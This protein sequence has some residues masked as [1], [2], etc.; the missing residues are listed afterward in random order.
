M[1][2]LD[3]KYTL[4]SMYDKRNKPGLRKLTSLQSTPSGTCQKYNGNE[5]ILKK[6]YKYHHIPNILDQSSMH[7]Q[8]QADFASEIVGVSHTSAMLSDAG[9]C[10]SPLLAAN[11]FRV[12]FTKKRV[13]TT[14]MM[15]LLGGYV[16]KS[17]SGLRLE[18]TRGKDR[19]YVMKGG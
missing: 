5:K 15:E 2:P 14:G 3:K 10:E 18:L 16:L 13:K 19:G 1:L 8:P 9:F 6:H 11:T 7:F 4:K 17:L 12:S